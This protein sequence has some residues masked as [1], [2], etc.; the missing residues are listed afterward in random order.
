MAAMS[1]Y[2]VLTLGSVDRVGVCAGCGFSWDATPD[3]ATSEV[4]RAA[5]R[6]SAL[7]DGLGPEGLR[8]RPDESVW[9]PIEY[10]GH[11]RDVAAFYTDRIEQV[12]TID[13]PRLDVAGFVAMVE[14]RRSVSD[15]RV[16]LA[17]LQ[18][19]LLRASALLARLTSGDWQ[20]VGIGSEGDERTVLD[21][22]RRLAHELCH[23]RR[24]LEAAG[25]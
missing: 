14:A 17:E 25:R 18:E 23:H 24:D 6:Y 11:V 5:A 15:A 10:L 8:Q 3:Q 9:S 1:D 12:A 22:V 16:V 13:R 20:R 7:L 2:Q 4:E 21:L 19:S